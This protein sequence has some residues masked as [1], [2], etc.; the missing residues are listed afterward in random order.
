MSKIKE[1]S[2]SRS[3]YKTYFY[4]SISTACLIAGVDAA[5]QVPGV[6]FTLCIFP[7]LAGGVLFLPPYI[8]RWG[9]PMWLRWVLFLMLIGACGA[10]SAVLHIPFV[11][12]QYQG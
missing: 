1:K 4:W 9:I 6:G 10:V 11:P 5:M 12:T 7:Y 8:E 3:K 2:P